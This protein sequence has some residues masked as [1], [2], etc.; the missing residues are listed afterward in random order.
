MQVRRCRSDAVL[1]GGP[2]A[3]AK[4]RGVSA[5]AAVNGYNRSDAEGYVDVL[6]RVLLARYQL[7]AEH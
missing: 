1:A 7:A 5:G 4:P 6:E 3:F 2:P